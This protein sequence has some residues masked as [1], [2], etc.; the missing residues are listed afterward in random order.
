MKKTVITVLCILFIFVLVITFGRK[1]KKTDIDDG[2]L[3]VVATIFPQYDFIRQI[4]GDNVNLNMLISPGAETH[5]YEPTPQ[6]IIKINNSDVFIFVGGESDA[7]L[8]KILESLDD[9]KNRT[10]ISLMDIVKPVKEEIAE[11]MQEEDEESQEAE[12]DEH[13]WTSPRNAQAIVKYLSDTLQNKDSAN[14]AL[15]KENAAVYIKKLQALDASF[16]DIVK[17]GKRKTIV[18]GDRFPFRYFTDA[19]GLRYFAAFP[20]CSNETEA[21]PNTIAF[22]I[23]KIKDEKIPVIFYIELSN[24]KIADIIS[25][26]S[27][28]KKLH[29]HSAQNVSKKDFDKGVSYLDLMEKNIESLKEALWL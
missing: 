22:L 9:K 12:Y 4:A 21:N 24:E 26:S 1:T 11:G 13:V 5:S 18:F 29:L 8:E 19:Y 25:E 16:K 23:N 7:W 27:K 28:A 15:Y 2:K 17:G 3:N 14:A 20:G 6:D 10:I